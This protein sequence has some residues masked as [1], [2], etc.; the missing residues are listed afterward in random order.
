MKYTENYQL[1]QWVETDRIRMEDFNGDNQKIDAALKAEATARAAAV[2]T[3]TGKVA[4]CGNCRIVYGSYKGT[5][6]AGADNPCKMTFDSKPLFL[7]ITPQSHSGSSYCNLI[8]VQGAQ[9]AYSY[10]EYFNSNN[11]VTWDGNT[12]Q[13]YASKSAE[14]QFNTTMTYHYVALLAA[15]E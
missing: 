10:V 7:F 13:W 3:L 5:G 12:V 11:H 1:S 4:K 2:Q 8:L 15:D 9:W 14:Y 6:Q